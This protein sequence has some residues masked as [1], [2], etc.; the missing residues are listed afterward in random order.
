MEGKRPLNEVREVQ[1][2]LDQYKVTEIVPEKRLVISVHETDLISTAFQTLVQNKIMS[3]PVFS[4]TRGFYSMIDLFDIIDF[5]LTVSKDDFKQELQR[6][7]PIDRTAS[8]HQPSEILSGTEAFAKIT[9]K[10]LQQALHQE[11]FPNV[12]HRSS[13]FEAMKYMVQNKVHRVVIVDSERSL[14]GII[15]QTM[16]IRFLNSKLHLEPLRMLGNCLMRD[17]PMHNPWRTV[18]ITPDKTAYD[19][20]AVMRKERVSG[21]PVV[22]TNGHLIG[23]VSASDIKAIGMDA[24]YLHALILPLNDYFTELQGRFNL[25]GFAGLK[26]KQTIKYTEDDTLR[27]VCDRLATHRVHR[28]Y[29]VDAAGTLKGVTSLSEIMK[30]LCA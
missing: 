2:W 23:N 20:F 13:L 17:I 28:I 12:D 19:A 14:H 29:L 15:T 18:S 9:V 26:E 16:I 24:H 6:L 22:D 30:V 27:Q 3:V 4:E 7:F 11:K 5:A 25:P 10:D 21:V 1:K 8:T